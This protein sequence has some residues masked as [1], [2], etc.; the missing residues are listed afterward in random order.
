[1]DSTMAMAMEDVMATWRQR[2]RWMAQRQR[3][4]EDSDGRHKGDG[5]RDIDGDGRRG[6]DTAVTTA[7]VLKN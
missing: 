3:D 6:G 1:M 7:T 2:R 4:G 5:R